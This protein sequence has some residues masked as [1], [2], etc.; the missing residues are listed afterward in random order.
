[1]SEQV[2]NLMIENAASSVEMEGFTI[3]EQSKAW[4]RQLLQN[5]ITLAEYI[6]LVKEKAGVA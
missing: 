5:E 3:D 2:M 1:M 6:S 4:C